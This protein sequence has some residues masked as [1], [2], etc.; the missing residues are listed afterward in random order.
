[1]Q[2]D[3][4]PHKL[5]DLPE[6][7]FIQVIMCPECAKEIKVNVP[8]KPTS[9]SSYM[10]TPCQECQKKIRSERKKDGSYRIYS[11]SSC[12]PAGT[13][14]ETPYG[15]RDIDSIAKNEIVL[16]FNP[17]QNSFFPRKI[18][19]VYKHKK[20]TIWEVSFTDGSKVRTT[21]N[22]SFLVARK[23]RR[24]RQIHKGDHLSSIDEFGG[25]VT[26]QVVD[27]SSTSHMEEVFN[28]V[29]EGDFS[30]IADGII[31]HSFSYF[32]EI[33]I[34]LWTLKSLTNSIFSEHT[35]SSTI[36]VN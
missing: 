23:W 9:D 11:I 1:M 18:L 28:L 29:V 33:R 13:L 8:A 12:F 14:I 5:S 27:C 6:V 32:R 10:D 25:H 26:R 34:L 17:K 36:N 20:N 15:L 22:H 35:N 4:P 3:P 19:K 21:A 2:S 30:F 24:T 31:A 7:M 16:A